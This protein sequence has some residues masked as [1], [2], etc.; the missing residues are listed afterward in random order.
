MNLTDTFYHE[1]K[2]MVLTL[3]QDYFQNPADAEDAVQEVF[4]KLHRVHRLIPKG[5]DTKPWVYRVSDNLL[6]DLLRKEA[7]RQKLGRSLDYEAD[8]VVDFDDPCTHNER[9]ES[10]ACF[11]KNFSELEEPYLTTFLLRYEE[12]LSYEAIAERTEVP[13]GTV[14]SRIKRAKEYL[15]KDTN[16]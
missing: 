4:L 12:G 9:E 6:K 15:L 7:N 1:H 3:A 13:I 8:D 5:E 14:S 2:K 16:E 10:A 11:M